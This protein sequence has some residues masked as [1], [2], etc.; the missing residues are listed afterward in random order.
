[1]PPNSCARVFGNDSK[2]KESANDHQENYE[3]KSSAGAIGGPRFIAHLSK[4][5]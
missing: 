4:A 3:H 2:E 1:M 5:L